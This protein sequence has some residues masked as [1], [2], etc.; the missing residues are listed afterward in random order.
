MP[1]ESPH[2][3]RGVSRLIGAQLWE[4]FGLLLRSVVRLTALPSPGPLPPALFEGVE[5]MLASYR[6]PLK[7]IPDVPGAARIVGCKLYTR[8]GET[9]NVQTLPRDA[10]GA[11]VLVPLDTDCQNAL[12]YFDAAGNETAE[13]TNSFHSPVR[14]EDPMP[15]PEP[16]EAPIFLG[17]VDEEPPPT[18]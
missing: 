1:T 4:V 8:F 12:R 10:T 17:F 5:G 7:P 16:L 14:P 6:Q 3:L 11:I 2:D 9:E 18:E 15:T 13:G